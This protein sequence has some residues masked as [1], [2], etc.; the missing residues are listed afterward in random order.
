[1]LE[2]SASATFSHVARAIRTLVDA[3]GQ[4]V[5]A[6]VAVGLDAHHVL[7]VVTSDGPQPAIGSLIASDQA[8]ENSPTWRLISARGIEPVQVATVRFGNQTLAVAVQGK[9]PHAVSAS[10]LSATAELAARALQGGALPWRDP[11]TGAMTRA[12][13]FDEVNARLRRS[14][15]PAAVLLCSVD[16]TETVIDS[17]GWAT[18]DALLRAVHQRLR[19]SLP[20]HTPIAHL[21]SDEFAI[22]VEGGEG[23]AVAERLVDALSSPVVADGSEVPLR[24]SVGLAESAP[25]SDAAT[26]LRQ[27][28]LAVQRANTHAGGQWARFAGEWDSAAVQRLAYHRD[29]S[30]ALERGELQLDYQPVLHAAPEADSAVVGFE[31][32]L[33]WHHPSRGLISPGE[34]VPVAEE[35]GLIV[36]IGRWVLL[37]ACRRHAAWRDGSCR[38]VSV[39]ISA[40]QLASPDIVADVRHA[41]DESG[42]PPHA[43]V[44]EVTETA[45]TRDL[46]LAAERLVR[47]REL[48]VHVALDDFGTGYSSLTQLQRLPATILKLDRSFV[49]QI[50]VSERGTQ[51]AE[52]I[53]SMASTLELDTVAEGVEHPEQIPVLRRLGCDFLQGFCLHRPMTGDAIDRLMM[54]ESLEAQPLE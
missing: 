41:L 25:G 4:A 2:A 45:A 24:G 18:G 46:D 8:N 23:P 7:R 47:L 42:L 43:L 39:N 19:D 12:A 27:A 31:A 5:T 44:V 32:L 16:S 35:T 30:Y 40:A 38:V 34:F 20:A 6:H 49:A 13:F 14:P 33:R 1:M 51:M 36:P 11:T 54:P 17:L 15:E 28:H 37:E 22:L 10:S 26:L 53:L 3:D 21:R 52:A 9:G 29:L 48:G 50:G